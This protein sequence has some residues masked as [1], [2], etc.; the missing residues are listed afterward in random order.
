[1]PGLKPRYRPQF[2]VNHIEEAK[3]I[4][5]KHTAPHNM[6]QRAKLVQLLDEHP[7]IENPQAARLL[8]RHANWVRYW[9]K[10]WATDEFSLT[11]K[12][13]S[14]RKPILT[15]ND[16]T[17]I[18]A[19]ACEFPMQRRQ[20]LS[21]YSTMD[22]VRVVQAEPQLAHISPSSVWRILDHDAIKPWRFRCWI[23]PRDPEFLAKARPILE[24]YQG[25]W[26]GQ[27]L[28]AREFVIS[29]DE[30]TSIQARQRRYPSQPPRPNQLALF[31]H[32]Y[33]RQGAL[34]YLAALDVHHM[35]LVGRC[36]PKTGKAAFGR[37]VDDVMRQPPYASAERVFWIV[38]NGSSHRGPK[39][40][41]ELRERY[42]NLIL[43]HLPIHASWLN[44][45][46]IYFSILQRKVLTPNDVT[47]ITE[48]E[49]RILAFQNYY[50]KSAKPFKWKYTCQDLKQQFERLKLAA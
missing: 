43:V 29:A 36:E 16:H 22:I 11:D 20:P 4:S 30:K 3:R 10:R 49:Q 13:R 28:G 35:R 45:I 24:L 5:H 31:E 48:L 41:A 39:A 26:Q 14:G 19:I 2:T 46:E 33:R 6:V 42:D 34:Q 32:E 47:D 18:K 21:R 23:F 7:D 15:A 25:L 1:M 37:L 9:R 44:Q 8:G 38:D 40:A 17:L 27:P 12:P 50:M